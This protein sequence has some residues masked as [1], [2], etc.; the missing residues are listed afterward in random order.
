MPRPTSE[1]FLERW[2]P[3]YLRW[4]D[5]GA[6]PDNVYSRLARRVAVENHLPPSGHT[7]IRAISV[8]RRILDRRNRELHREKRS[9][10]RE[11]RLSQDQIREAIGMRWPGALAPYTLNFVRFLTKDL[12]AAQEF[13]LAQPGY[14][15]LVAMQN[16]VLAIEE[17][18]LHVDRDITQLN[19]VLR[20]RRLALLRYEFHV[21]ADARDRA[22]YHRLLS[23]EKQ[24][25]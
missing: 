20:L 6:E 13:I 14:P 17:Q 1:M 3:W 19:K 9:L 23:C 24:P 12:N 18:Q 22:E 15:G 4:V 5:T 8:R 10:K 7:L 16:R 11:I 21:D 2:Q 25:L